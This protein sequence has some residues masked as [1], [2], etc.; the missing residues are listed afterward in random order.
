MKTAWMVA[1]WMVL[2]LPAKSVA[3]GGA[4]KGAAFWRQLDDLNKVLYVRGF[5]DGAQVAQLRVLQLYEPETRGL[6]FLRAP[7]ARVPFD[8]AV[9]ERT[10]ELTDSG[11]SGGK[12]VPAIALIDAL[13]TDPA[14]A[15]ISRSAMVVA[16]LGKL[17]GWSQQ[18][19]DEYL[20]KMRANFVD[21]CD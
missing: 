5:L 8:S 2:A 17:S 19:L 13:Y 6:W 21:D 15:C 3:Q 1:L 18:I 20:A 16:A 14:N 7:R 9:V 12:I 11:G 4:T 10:L